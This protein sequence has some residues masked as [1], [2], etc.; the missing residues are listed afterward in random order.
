MFITEVGIGFLFIET[1][2]AFVMRV[3]LSLW[4]EFHSSIVWNSLESVDIRSSLTVS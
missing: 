2:F 4:N 1:L 3:I